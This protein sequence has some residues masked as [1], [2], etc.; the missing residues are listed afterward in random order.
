MKVVVIAV[1]CVLGTIETVFWIKV[2]W[3]WW[4]GESVDVEADEEGK[5][6]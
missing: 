1:V 4:N 5:K 6:G 2:G 3:R